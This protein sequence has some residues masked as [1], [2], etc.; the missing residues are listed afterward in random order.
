MPNLNM[1][2]VS[3]NFYSQLAGPGSPSVLWNGM[4]YPLLQMTI[5]GAIWYQGEANAG[6]NQSA[7]NRILMLLNSVY[8]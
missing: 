4:M 7:I 6:I 3:H 1:I 2:C 8:R 5:Y